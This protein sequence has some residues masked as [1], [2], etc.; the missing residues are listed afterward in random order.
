MIP[1]N[2]APPREETKLEILSTTAVPIKGTEGPKIMPK[3][4]LNGIITRAISIIP[5]KKFL[6]VSIIAKLLS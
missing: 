2:P 5:L 4:T 3:T 1:T 6:T